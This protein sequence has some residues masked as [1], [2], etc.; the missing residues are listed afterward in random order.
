MKFQR[1]EHLSADK[2][3]MLQ[4]DTYSNIRAGRGI[5]IGHDHHGIVISADRQ[6]MGVSRVGG[7]GSG[8]ILVCETTNNLNNYKNNYIICTPPGGGS[9][10]QV[11][12]PYILW[13]HSGTIHNVNHQS[14][15]V[16][17]HEDLYHRV[18]MVDG[19]REVQTHTP[20]Y[21]FNEII[22]ASYVVYPRS[23]LVK[24]NIIN[25]VDYEGDTVGMLT[26]CNFA[27]RS[28]AKLPEWWDM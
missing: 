14:V 11:L 28:W 13:Q 15:R 8:D 23:L 4:P 19:Y 24:Y 3:N 27:G 10:I 1:G 5:H 16:S 9:P 6:F 12:L 17:P 25:A 18:V 22:F 26:D 2:M 20:S 7:G 21:Q